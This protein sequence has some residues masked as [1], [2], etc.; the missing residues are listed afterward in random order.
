MGLWRSGSSDPGT[1][2]RHVLVQSGWCFPFCLLSTSKADPRTMLERCPCPF[3]SLRQTHVRVRTRVFHPRFHWLGKPDS[4]PAMSHSASSTELCPQERAWTR[5]RFLRAVVL[6][7]SAVVSRPLAKIQG[8]WALIEM[9][10]R[11][12]AN[13][14][15]SPSLWQIVKRWLDLKYNRW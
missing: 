2:L 4:D 8:S 15:C 10:Q 3:T 6:Q 5:T 13:G 9:R 12:S 11:P 7:R 1:L 14:P